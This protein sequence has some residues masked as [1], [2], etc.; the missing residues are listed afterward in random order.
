MVIVETTEL[1][2]TAMFTLS[3]G[4]ILSNAVVLGRFPVTLGRLWAKLSRVK[5]VRPSLSELVWPSL[6]AD[7]FA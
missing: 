2:S 5:T 4:L 1:I 6:D 3:S 7:G